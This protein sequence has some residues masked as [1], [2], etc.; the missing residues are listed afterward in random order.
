MVL[1][2]MKNFEFGHAQ[3]DAKYF[4]SQNESTGGG[5]LKSLEHRQL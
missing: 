1:L 5:A 4:N 2:V 3:T